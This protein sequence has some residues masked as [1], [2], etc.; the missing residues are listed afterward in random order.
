MYEHVGTQK[1]I[2]DTRKGFL[3]LRRLVKKEKGVACL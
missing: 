1:C 2:K 3:L